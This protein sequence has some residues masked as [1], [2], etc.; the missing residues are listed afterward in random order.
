MY[1]LNHDY[2]SSCWKRDLFL[3]SDPVGYYMSPWVEGSSLAALAP[4]AESYPSLNSQAKH[5]S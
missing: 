5:G 2:Y 1:V 4:A 3:D